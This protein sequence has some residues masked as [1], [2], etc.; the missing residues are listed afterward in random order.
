VPGI[1]GSAGTSFLQKDPAEMESVF[2]QNLLEPKSE[3]A[4]AR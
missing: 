4:V 3:Q 2:A 1:V